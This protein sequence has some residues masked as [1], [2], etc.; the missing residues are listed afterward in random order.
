MNPRHLITQPRLKVPVRA[1]KCG[2]GCNMK[3]QSNLSERDRAISGT[4]K[5]YKPQES[6]VNA[7]DLAN[8]LE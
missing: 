8:T 4:H 2:E 5:L 6:Y 7:T 1:K 3:G